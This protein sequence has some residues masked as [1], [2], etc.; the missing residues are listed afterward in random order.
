MVLFSFSHAF[1][2]GQNANDVVRFL[3]V[4]I[5][6]KATKLVNAIG[7]NQKGIIT[8]RPKPQRRIFARV[9]N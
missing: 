1:E 2:E 4:D 7:K 8:V 5:D 9:K 3:S 6:D